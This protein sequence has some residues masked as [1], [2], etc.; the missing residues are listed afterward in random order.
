[1]KKTN[2]LDELPHFVV[3]GSYKHFRR[4]HL[5]RDNV[6]VELDHPEPKFRVDV[7]CEGLQGQGQ[8]ACLVYFDLLLC[9][10]R[11]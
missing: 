3:S 6:F 9:C 1:M 10:R 11:L 7:L 5:L 8:L 4:Q 2:R